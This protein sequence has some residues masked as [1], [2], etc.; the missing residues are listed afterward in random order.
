MFSQVPYEG[1]DSVIRLMEKHARDPDP[2]KVDLIPGGKPNE[3]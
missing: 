1:S 2:N 3:M